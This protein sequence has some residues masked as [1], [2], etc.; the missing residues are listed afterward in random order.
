MKPV[1]KQSNRRRYF[2][3]DTAKPAL[4]ALL[5]EQCSYCERAG[6]PQD[7][8]VEHI[9]PVNGHPSQS[10]RWDNFLIACNTCNTYKRLHIGDGR[11][12]SLLTRYL[13]PHTDNTANAFRYE[14]T[15]QVTIA[16][17]AQPH[18]AREEK[19]KINMA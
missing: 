1:N 17:I 18:L 19:E 2:P 11:Q 10:T 9:Y 13:W 8:H 6:V 7:L 16:M 12:R 3:Y 4:L 15:G 5:G 14:S